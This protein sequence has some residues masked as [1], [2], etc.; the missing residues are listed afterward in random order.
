MSVLLMRWDGSARCALV[1]AK[2][3]LFRDGV[4]NWG[5]IVALLELGGA[6][7]AQVAKTDEAWQVDDIAGWMVDSL[8][9]PRLQG[10]IE[11]SGGWV[12]GWKLLSRFFN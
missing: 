2:A 6:L 9:S 3:D 4:V 5:G 10:W 8:D 1:A 12:G 7:C 11:D